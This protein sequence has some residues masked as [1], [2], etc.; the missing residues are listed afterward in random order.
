MQIP[1]AQNRVAPQVQ[2]MPRGSMDAAAAP[3]RAVAQVGGVISDLGE[4]GMSLATQIQQKKKNIKDSTDLMQVNNDLETKLSL[5]NDQAAV[6]TDPKEI[7]K[8]AGEWEQSVRNGI[9]YS[10]YSPEVAERVKLQVD[11]AVSRGKVNA[12]GQLDADGNPTSGFAFKAQVKQMDKPLVQMQQNALDGKW[13]LH[14]VTGEQMKPEEAF[15]YATTERM[16]LGT[17]TTEEGMKEQRTFGQN[18]A[19]TIAYKTLQ[20]DYNKFKSTYEPEKLSPFQQQQISLAQSQIET[21]ISR[22]EMTQSQKMITSLNAKAD[23]G[24]LGPSDLEQMKIPV[25]LG[26]GVTAS[27]LSPETEQMYHS[28]IMGKAASD[29]LSPKFIAQYAKIN[30]MK[31][32]PWYGNDVTPEKVKVLLKDLGKTKYSPATN[33]KIMKDVGDIFTE[34]KFFDPAANVAAYK[35][36][37]YQEDLS[38]EIVSTFTRVIEHGDNKAAF[39]AFIGAFDSM[40]NL[41]KEKGGGITKEDVDAWRATNLSKFH[42]D[43]AKAE[44]KNR[45]VA[46]PIQQTEQTGDFVVDKIYTDANGLKAKWNGSSWEGV[47]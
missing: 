32:T 10:Q 45:N 17:Q 33:L 31:R 19:Y 25:D 46:K 20:S 12:Y 3:W 13:G 24:Q 28:V 26:H 2:S 5:F 23:A 38:K 39:G 14:P 6:Q 11:H 35:M 42:T 36:K 43:N 41:F 4:K 22:N 29:E 44:L 27:L 47:K 21:E 15:A 7:V 8:F 37:S 40:S 18:Q 1:F 9:D 16:K 34:G 30:N